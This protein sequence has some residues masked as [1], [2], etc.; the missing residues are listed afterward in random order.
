MVY[1]FKKEG[2]VGHIYIFGTITKYA[3]AEYGEVS[4][5]TFK[6]EVDKIIDG[7]DELV[8]HINSPG[9]DVVE[10]LGIISVM[11]ALSIPI[12]CINDGAAFSM[13]AVVLQSATKRVAAKGSLLMLHSASTGLYGNKAELSDGAEMLDKF[14]TAIATIVANRCG[15]SVEEVKQLYFDGKDHF[16][17]AEEAL[18]ANLIDE[19]SDKQA[20]LPNN[21]A[22]TRNF[23]AMVAA[24]ANPDN[25]TPKKERVSISQI[26]QQIFTP[27][28]S[29]SMDELRSILDLD[30]KADERAAVSAI[31]GIISARD[32]AIKARDEANGKVEAL[33]GEVSDL[34]KQLDSVN[35]QLTAANNRIDEQQKIIDKVPG[36]GLHG[37]AEGADTP[38]AS[39][40]FVSSDPVMAKAAKL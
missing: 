20:V 1:N 34:K 13:A 8:I 27:K 39:D 7:C 10:G 33:G 2:N 14:D 3:W 26:V 36:M 32:E 6:S 25:F 21:V 16:L 22:D 9:G 35:G 11:E 18:A 37:G 28:N 12:T 15:Q 23:T 40:E 29:F 38:P 5:M 24:Y 17:T 31:Q 19:I 4:S 30:K